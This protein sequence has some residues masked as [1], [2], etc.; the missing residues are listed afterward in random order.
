MFED[1]IGNNP[2]K[3][4]FPCKLEKNGK[5]I[6]DAVLDMS[7]YLSKKAGY[8]TCDGLEI[9]KYD[10]FILVFPYSKDKHIVRITVP[11]FVRRLS[12]GRIH[13]VVKGNKHV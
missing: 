7:E 5:I 2:K 9:T 1:I 4:K 11:I 10:C 13:F 3:D 8:I 12:D 6:E